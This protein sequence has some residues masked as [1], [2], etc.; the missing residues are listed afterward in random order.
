VTS[1]PNILWVT[2]DQHRADTLGSAG[3]PC[4]RTPHL[5]KLAQ[6]GVRFTNAYSTCPVCVPQR[7]SWITGIPA[8]RY[9]CPEYNDAYRIDRDPELFLGSLVTEAGYQTALIGKKH[10]HT[11]PDFNA[12]FESYLGFDALGKAIAEHTGRPGGANFSGIGNNEWHPAQ[13]HLPA[14]L[15]STDWAIDRAIQAAEGFDDAAPFFLW[16]SLTDPHPPNAIHEPYY[17]MYFRSP[18]PEPHIPD[19][20]KQ[21]PQPDWLRV[22]HGTYSVPP[23]GVD[24][25]RD[26][27][28]VYYGKITNLDH[29]LGRLIA[30]LQDQGAWDNTL[31][32]YTSDHGEM[33]GD[34]SLFAKSNFL[35]ASSNVP[36]IVRPPE[37]WSGLRG[38]SCDTLCCGE[39]LL[40]TFCEATGATRPTDTL[41]CNLM[42]LIDGSPRS[43]DEPFIHGNIKTQHMLRDDR[44]KFIYDSADG[45]RLLFDLHNDP[46]EAE[47]FPPGHRLLDEYFIRL[48][49]QLAD[50]GRTF[51]DDPPAATIPRRI[52]ATGLRALAN[53]GNP[54]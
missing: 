12:G 18:I 37:N 36:L 43:G 40:P 28:A 42:D 19:W 10:W 23:M 26:A 25:L 50:E 7:T 34:F 52:N 24:E 15:Y 27:R 4:V 9:G 5:D 3:H 39:D 14:H 45:S 41:G 29:Q 30:T 6:D 21:Q 53:R 22:Q 38:Q 13:T 49:R 33:L 8:H 20:V 51:D 17:S 44:Y 54:I 2:S 32:V 11:E 16:L 48:K 1:Q 46:E 35:E 31:V 47:P